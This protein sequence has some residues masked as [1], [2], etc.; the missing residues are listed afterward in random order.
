MELYVQIV[1]FLQCDR[2]AN[3]YSEH[4]PMCN[5]VSKEDFREENNNPNWC[6]FNLII[7]LTATGI[8]SAN[9]KKYN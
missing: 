3:Y 1:F 6:L 2:I 5:F 8:P 4:A 7:S 9:Q